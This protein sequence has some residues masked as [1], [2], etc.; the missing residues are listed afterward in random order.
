MDHKNTIPL[1]I[2]NVYKSFKDKD[3]LNNIDLQIEKGEIFGLVGI[4]GVGKTTLIKVML[5]LLQQ[6]KGSV[7]FFGSDVANIKTRKN[8]AYLPEKFHPSSYLKGKEFLELCLS[9]Y[10]KK[11]DLELAKKMAESLDLDPAVLDY[12]ISKYSKGM[13]QKLGLLSTFLVDVPLLLLD[14]PMSGLDPKARIRLKDLLLDY[15]NKGNTVFFSSHILI[16]V[17]EICDRIAVINEGRV[18]FCGSSKELLKK[19]KE[20]NLERA[21]LKAIDA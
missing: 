13:G 2:S 4:N 8:I 12:K 7:S 18:I 11:F 14:E 3:V 9:F 16:D 21:F 15:K 20:K 6:D 5:N 19:H 10:K 17:E 1:K